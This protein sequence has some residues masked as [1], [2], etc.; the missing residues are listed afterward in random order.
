MTSTG[1]TTV[2]GAPF[3]ELDIPFSVPFVPDLDL[4]M[5]IYC[6]PLQ[7]ICEGFDFDLVKLLRVAK[8]SAVTSIFVVAVLYPEYHG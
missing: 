6:I 8:L 4:A 1:P 7:A 5:N 3:T 2:S